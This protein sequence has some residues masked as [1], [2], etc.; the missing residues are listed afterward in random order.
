M[1][2]ARNALAWRR[3][4]HYLVRNRGSKSRTM[5]SCGGAEPR[6]RSVTPGHQVA[7]TPSRDATRQTPADLADEI[8]TE[9]GPWS[10][11][12]ARFWPLDSNA[13]GSF[14]VY[15]DVGEGELW[16]S[17][18]LDSRP[19]TRRAATVL[20]RSGY[21]ILSVRSKPFHA[22]RP[23]RGL[24]ELDAEVRRLTTLSRDRT[25]IAAFPP[26]VLRQPGLPAGHG[27]FST[28]AFNHLRHK[29]DWA[30]E[31]VSVCR[32]GPATLVQ[33]PWAMGAW[34]LFLDD[35][36]DRWV[37]LHVQLFKRGTL[38]PTTIDDD[39][40]RLTRAVRQR[41]GPLGYRPLRLR[42]R[43]NT[44]FAVFEKR[45]DTLSIARRERARLDSV[46]FGD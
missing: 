27:P 7:L 23:L 5:P 13:P 8:L 25:T 36:D 46:V 37:D 21:E 20:R 26:R 31:W 33:A 1:A 19:E 2:H 41:L 32:R 16:S 39:F 10:L 28:A 12:G 35:G 14:G 34:C 45:V 30:L 11:S 40:A 17:V 6:H 24:R 29:R 42:G 3:S 9:G 4:R 18:S 44:H 22:R 38:G 15:I 43:M